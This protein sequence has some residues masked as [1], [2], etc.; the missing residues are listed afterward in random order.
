M[1][2]VPTMCP[3]WVGLRDTSVRNTE[4][5]P[6]PCGAHILMG[7][8]KLYNSLNKE[9]N[10]VVYYNGIGVIERNNGMGAS[11]S[12]VGGYNFRWLGWDRPYWEETK[13]NYL[14]II[15]EWHR[16]KTERRLL[17]CSPFHS[18]D[19]HFIPQ[20]SSVWT[21]FFQTFSVS[22]RTNVFIK[23]I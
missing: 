22:F 1:Y 15:G 18:C 6:C 2:Y 8:G 16:I 5:N 17:Y 9:V 7:V 21:V 10:Y 3:V 19:C 12:V 23:K 14:K 11:G 13:N 4:Q 20:K